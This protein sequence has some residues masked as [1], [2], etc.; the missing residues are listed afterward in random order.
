MGSPL[1]TCGY[2]LFAWAFL[3]GESGIGILDEWESLNWV[4]SCAKVCNSVIYSATSLRFS[5][6]TCRLMAC[7]IFILK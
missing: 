2:L 3:E 4:V 7:G 1:Y 5:S 6:Q